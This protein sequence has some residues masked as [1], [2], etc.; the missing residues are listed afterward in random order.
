MFSFY[1]N[2]Y[3][4]L[5]WQT[6]TLSTVKA[7]RMGFDTTKGVVNLRITSVVGSG[8]CGGGGGGRG[9]GIRQHFFDP[10][11]HTV[12]NLLTPFLQLPLLLTPLPSP[13]YFRQQLRQC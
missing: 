2:T 4:G 7:L 5:I 10:P 13:A 11:P 6:V 8:V 1:N 3:L 12:Q 9:L